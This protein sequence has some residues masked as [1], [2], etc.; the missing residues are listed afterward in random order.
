[1][2]SVEETES[3][4]IRKDREIQT[5][6]NERTVS[7]KDDVMKWWKSNSTRYPLLQLAARHVLAIPAT[8]ATSERLFS[9]AGNIVTSNRSKLLP[10]N[11]EKLC[12]LHVNLKK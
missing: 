6:M 2:G 4:D 11:I 3:F 9:A 5:Y 7:R 1:M 12:F 10:E 8:Q